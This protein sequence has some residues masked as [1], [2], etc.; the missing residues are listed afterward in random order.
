MQSHFVTEFSSN[1]NALVF[2]ISHLF[3]NY[4]N[5]F[6]SCIHIHLSQNRLQFWKFNS[7]AIASNGWWWFSYGLPRHVTY[8]SILQIETGPRG[9]WFV[10]FLRGPLFKWPPAHAINAFTHNFSI[11]FHNRVGELYLH[12]RRMFSTWNKLFIFIKNFKTIPDYSQ[13]YKFWVFYGSA[14]L[15]YSQLLHQRNISQDNDQLSSNKHR[16]EPIIGT[17]WPIKFSSKSLIG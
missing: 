14:N 16:T 2:Q 8:P 11:I 3:L 13:N 10:R 12:Y 4:L 5:Y 15:H 6:S 7:I 9:A 17:S 1:Y